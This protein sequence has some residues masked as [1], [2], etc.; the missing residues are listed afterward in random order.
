MELKNLTT[1]ISLTGISGVVGGMIGAYFKMLLDKKK[2]ISLSLNRINE[3]RYCNILNH[4]NIALNPENVRFMNHSDPK[5]GKQFDQKD[6]LDFLEA[7]YMQS[8]LYAPDAVVKALKNFLEEPTKELF[9][10]TA[11]AM[12]VSLW[13]QKSNL[14]SSD[15]RLN[16]NAERI[17]T[18]DS[19]GRAVLTE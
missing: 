10:D 5:T 9:I 6:H 4:M 3:E 16:L 14:S 11:K 13:Q 1:I 17:S 19:Q 8:V 7:E 12:R 18:G 15:I 2:E